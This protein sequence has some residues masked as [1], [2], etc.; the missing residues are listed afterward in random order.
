MY[1]YLGEDPQYRL[2]NDPLLGEEIRCLLH[3]VIL[4]FLLSQ[5]SCFHF[6]TD[7]SL[8]SFFI[9][10]YLFIVVTKNWG[11][12]SVSFCGDTGF[13]FLTSLQIHCVNIWNLIWKKELFSHICM[14][15]TEFIYL[16]LVHILSLF[17]MSRYE[18][19]VSCDHS[20]KGCSIF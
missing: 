6:I 12:F 8:S 14:R 17:Y 7:I 2:R 5:P 18:P 4:I 20:I 11:F 3:C 13:I 16:R 9:T 1:N 10:F 19:D 15:D